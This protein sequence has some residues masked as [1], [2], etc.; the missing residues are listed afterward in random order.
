M[1]IR[2]KTE[3]DILSPDIRKVICA[4]IRGPEEERRREQ[5]YI[6]NLIHK[7]KTKELSRHKLLQMF[8][9][10]T[11]DSM[12]YALANISIGR[13][14]VDKLARVYS[15]G[16]E[17]MINDNDVE[18]EKLQ[19]LSKKLKTTAKMK[20]SNSITRLQR[21]SIVFSKPIIED[22]PDGSKVGY[23]QQTPMAPYLYSAIEREVDRTRPMVYI[24][25]NY[26]YKEPRV[27]SS[28]EP[29]N[30]S[31]SKA[32]QDPKVV[33]KFDGKDQTIADSPED[34]NVGEVDRFIWWSDH[35]HFVTNQKGEIID[36]NNEPMHIT[37]ID[38]ERIQNEIEEMPITNYAIGQ[39]DQFWAQGGEDLIDGSILINSMITHLNHVGVMQGHG[40]L[41]GR[42]RNLP[43]TFATGA[44][45][46]IMLEQED[47]EVQPEVGY[48]S[49]SPQLAELRQCIEMYVALL[50]TTNN[51][52]TS[53]VST[54]LNA[55]QTAASGVALI[56]DKADSLEDVQDQEQV[57][58][59]GEPDMWR[60][61]NKWLQKFQ[62][63]GILREDLRDLVLNQALLESEFTIEFGKPRTIMSEGELLDAI[64]KRK[65]LGLNTQIEL[66]KK[67]RPGI[68]DEEAEQ[69]LLEILAEKIARMAQA[70][71]L[72]PA[73]NNA[74]ENTEDEPPVEDDDADQGAKDQKLG[75]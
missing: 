31:H 56:I 7:D 17:R 41:W 64:A 5:S 54:Q 3:L 32:G 22:M 30:K 21:N 11:V 51:L 57:Y 69:K 49:A 70:M 1:E 2:L 38:D 34:A 33:Q 71:E 18:T 60:K 67:D 43:K 46:A 26:F 58:K 8:A 75:K 63:K 74:E 14:I 52:S 9:K 15:N 12:E 36:S 4:E 39:D 50:L 45:T 29:E 25:S 55:N 65:D 53:G 61:T 16:A 72:N 73:M 62:E 10:P 37:G 66:I 35:F 59:D 48:I 20:N 6:A 24:F 40:Q 68:T 27:Y 42:G 44:N 47:G 28:I 13:K 19:E 23:V